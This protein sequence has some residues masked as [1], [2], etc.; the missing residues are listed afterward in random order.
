MILAKIITKILSTRIFIKTFLGIRTGRPRAGYQIG[1]STLLMIKA[2]KK[3]AGKESRVLDIG[4]G[5][6]AIH[7]IWLVKNIG[8]HVTATEIN[9]DYL[10]N[11]NDT[12]RLNN[13]NIEIIKSDLFNGIKN[14]FDLILFNPPIENKRD[15]GSYRIAE[16][17]LKEAPKSRILMVVN[18]LY[19]DFGRIESLI[20]ANNYKVKGIV[21]AFMNPARVYLLE[22]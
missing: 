19:V 4:T 9:D 10:S 16:R 14:E 22:R 17:F 18:G 5:P 1:F 2:L 8:C 12:C 7:A 15:A 11:A 13:V 21:K 3:F 20:G 6:F